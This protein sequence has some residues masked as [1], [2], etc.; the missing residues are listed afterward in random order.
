MANAFRAIVPVVSVIIPSR[1]E[2][3]LPQ[4]IAD[5]LAH[6]SGDVEVIAVLDGYWPDPPLP[7][8]PRLRVL[9]HAESQG[10]RASINEAAQIARGRYLMK[11]DAH[12][13]VSAGFDEVL[14]SECDVD[15]V[16]IPRRD[17]LDPIGWCRQDTGKPPIDH[18]Y[19]NWPG[20]KPDDP[21][22]G[23]HGAI[24]PD[25]TRARMH[26]SLDD[27]MTTQG[28]CWFTPTE[29]FLRRCYPLDQAHYGNITHEAQEITLKA[30]LSGGQVKVNKRCQYLH[31]HKGRLYGRGYALGSSE[32]SRSTAHCTDYWM[33]DRWPDATKRLRWLIEK[34]A[35]VPTWPDDLD[36]VFSAIRESVACQ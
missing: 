4:T 13:S 1:N 25:R 15:W 31:L 10:M 27:E 30:W 17:R 22:C 34:F 19:L 24:W 11:L 5:V 18:H 21:Y 7:D 33:Y 8:D 6:A 16:V 23:L 20:F 29:Y 12:C 28:S 9:H 3:F 26:I 35:P 36:T 32:H 14:S 2:R